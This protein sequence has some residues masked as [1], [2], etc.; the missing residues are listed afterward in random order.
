MGNVQF[1]SVDARSGGTPVFKAAPLQDVWQDMMMRLRSSAQARASMLEGEK[2]E[3]GVFKHD[4]LHEDAAGWLQAGAKALHGCDF[5][6]WCKQLLTAELAWTTL[7]E[8]ENC[9]D[10]VSAV[11]AA[12]HVVDM[13]HAVHHLPALNEVRMEVQLL[14]EMSRRELEEATAAEEDSDGSDTGH[15]GDDAAAQLDRES[16]SG[17]EGASD[18]PVS[19]I[20]DEA[21]GPGGGGGAA[22][23]EIDVPTKE[24]LRFADEFPLSQGPQ[25]GL[26]PSSSA[27]MHSDEADAEHDRAND[28]DIVSAAE[29][30]D[31]QRRPAVACVPPKRARRL[32]E[33][34]NESSDDGGP[35][36]GAAV[37]TPDIRAF[38]S[39]SKKA[40]GPK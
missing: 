11:L 32:S 6:V 12:A 40:K 30:V 13:T 25:M 5:I 26:R 22:E 27:E 29:T 34:A 36:E 20:D 21:A 14:R 3:A 10:R 8:A 38:F 1:A 15:D 2:P 33:L 19:L 4:P 23:T 24:D 31:G 37:M 28:A 17:G 7:Q 18:G 35:G 39:A 16:E 9:S